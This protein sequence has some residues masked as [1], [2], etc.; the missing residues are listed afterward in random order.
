MNENIDLRARVQ[1][2][3]HDRLERRLD[4]R[5]E[6]QHAPEMSKKGER[7]GEKELHGLKREITHLSP[8]PRRRRSPV[9][10]GVMFTSTCIAARSCSVCART[11]ASRG[12][13]TLTSTSV[14][15]CETRAEPSAPACG[16]ESK[17]ISRS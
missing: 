1:V 2:R 7:L 10:N 3:L 16:D 11:R 9:L 17:V 8:R 6:L 15:P 13:N 4:H 12:P 5:R 14:S